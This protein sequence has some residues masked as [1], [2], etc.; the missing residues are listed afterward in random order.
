MIPLIPFTQNRGKMPV[1]LRS[2]WIYDNRFLFSE[3]PTHLR[4][5][6]QIITCILQLDCL[7]HQ[8]PNMSNRRI[9]EVAQCLPQNLHTWHLFQESIVVCGCT[10]GFY[11]SAIPRHQPTQDFMMFFFVSRLEWFFCDVIGMTKN[12]HNILGPTKKGTV[13]FS[14]PC[15]YGIISAV[16]HELTYWT[17]LCTLIS[18]SAMNL[19]NDELFLGFDVP[20]FSVKRVFFS[21]G[22]F[23]QQQISQDWRLHLRPGGILRWRSTAGRPKSPSKGVQKKKQKNYSPEI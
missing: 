13:W 4:F 12:H 10:S 5:L 1:N 9:L 3:K 18:F 7:A 14:P 15:D 22:E 16:T 6:P 2:S 8:V 17:K 20:I 21:P 11:Y 23:T 19:W